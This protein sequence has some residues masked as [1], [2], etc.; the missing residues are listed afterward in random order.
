VQ[1]QEQLEWEARVGRIVA[2]AAFASAVLALAGAAI[3][4]SALGKSSSDSVEFMFL[5]HAH[6]GAL[7]TST[8]LSV[9][10]TMLIAPAL[11]FL[12]MAAKY[13]RPQIPSVTRVLIV[14]I[15]IGAVFQLVRQLQ[16]A[17]VA[18]KVHTHLLATPLPPYQADDYV[19]HQFSGSP[20]QI[21]GAL[22]VALGLAIAFSFVLI[23][24]NAMRAG[25]LSRFMGYM[26]VAAGVLIVLPLG[27]GPVVQVF[28]LGALGLLFLG[29]WPQGGRGPAWE[30]GEADPWPTAADRQAEIAERRA[31]R[32]AEREGTGARARTPVAAGR[33]ARATSNGDEP[34]DEDVDY[35]EPATPRAQPH[36]RSK[37][38]KRKR[39]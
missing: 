13:R 17:H 36:P 35:D 32:D 9:I 26:G 4:N 5:V 33:G 18:D 23:G 11:W 34:D 30:T 39:R 7:I 3:Q 8:V 16:I 2:I 1:H 37:K 28:W 31:E 22:G 20:Y 19:K 14:A 24:I 29:R 25:L 12:Y 21:V 15:P 38:R 6:R 10:G 27:F